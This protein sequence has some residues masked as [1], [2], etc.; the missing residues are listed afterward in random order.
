MNWKQ[1]PVVQVSSDPAFIHI[2]RQVDT[3]AA[4]RIGGTM[5]AEQQIMGYREVP[6]FHQG[7]GGRGG[8]A[9][10]PQ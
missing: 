2:A 4:S 6:T 9:I 5:G 8:G 10:T 7:L 3:P 1:V